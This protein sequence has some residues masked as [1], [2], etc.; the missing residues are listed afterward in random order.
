MTDI[1]R[2]DR[3]RFRLS[4]LSQRTGAH[5]PELGLTGMVTIGGLFLLLQEE[6]V[7]KVAGGLELWQLALLA[8]PLPVAT[9][10]LTHAVRRRSRKATPQPPNG[11][12][13]FPDRIDLLIGRETE[14]QQVRDRA[15][16]SGIVVVR[17]PMGMGTSALA[18]RATWELAP[19]ARM[20]R[21]AD[22]RGPDRDRPET[23][24]SVA[25]RV[26]R[27]LDRPPG[28]IQEAADAAPQVI[29]ALTGTGRVLLLDNVSTWSQVA[30]L[31]PRVPGAHIVVAGTF[32]E[33]P[34]QR[35]E[36]VQLGPLGPE[37]GRDL[38][39]RH[40]GDDRAARDPRATGLLVDACLGSPL[41]IVRIGRWLA[42]NPGIPLKSLVDDLRM[43]S[44]DEKLGFLLDLSIRQLRPT[45][46]ELFVLLAGLPIAEVDHQA[47]AALLGLPS[48]EDAIRELAGL[49]L[50]ENV[51]MTRV[52]V[53]SAFR[54][55]GA[56]E[57]TPR[58]DAAWR[59]LVE[60]FAGQADV[61]AA[62]LPAAEARTWFAIEDRALLQVL[63]RPEPAP[64]TGRALGRIADGLET[65]FR[66]EQRHED[67]LR[68]AKAL[69]RAAK[70]LGDEHVQATAELRQCAVLLI[71]GDPRA[72]RR[73]F[74]EAA[75]LRVRVESWPAELHLEHAAILLADGDEFT[76][77]ESALV[78]YGQALSGGDVAG[79]ALRL[80]NVAALL[81]RK[82]QTLDHDG[83]GPEARRL[84]ADARAVLFQAL[85]LA[86]RAGD[87]GAE[88]HAEE[89]LALTHHYLDLAY[90]ARSHLERAER[91]YAENADEIGRARCLVQRA[92]ALLE[93][94]GQDTE[95]V[96][97]L[98]DDA[99]PGLPPAG[100]STALAHLHLGRLRP[101]RA[102][103]HRD[104]GLAALA[105]W[106]GIAEPRQVSEL[107]TR[108]ATL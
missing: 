44:I 93:D 86:G 24:L 94:P 15:K 19:E 88:A 107:R 102:G 65:W 36:P 91:L 96:A 42:R 99:L 50:V 6:L 9:A 72:A 38:L 79:H 89:L 63:A 14:L 69:A 12:L 17:G 3:V 26:L 68:A 4:R 46:K 71:A 47:A 31:P 29:D 40:I 59:R 30:W 54:G 8:I 52:R 104:A 34:P 7:K 51:R 39:A 67:R 33:E 84:Y 57:R 78:R 13:P 61:F 25:Q 32:T 76:A 1:S 23:P 85:D 49:G 105:P 37:A 21:Y 101:E 90:D 66:L 5:L 81:V 53:T 45:A 18:I 22:V 16:E 41:E 35:I 74:N 82:G 80:I 108:L 100:V 55:G 20:Q 97:K 95:E 103:E 48:A 10:W 62:R 75:D 43:L 56:E 83:H 28:V 11:R 64:K 98:L 27:T 92:G 77:V 106:D 70:A 58:V 2:R 60:H 87:P 73:H